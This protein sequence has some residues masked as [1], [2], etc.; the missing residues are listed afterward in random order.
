MSLNLR[1][2]IA[3]AVLIAS[4]SRPMPGPGNSFGRHE[5]A[6]TLLRADAV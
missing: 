1:P 3:D 4:I 5:H 6:E 2:L